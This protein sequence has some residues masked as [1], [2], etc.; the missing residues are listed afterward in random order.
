MNKILTSLIAIAMLTGMGNLYAAPKN[1]CGSLTTHY[2]PFDYRQRAHLNIAI[3]ENAHFTEE[4]EA[5]IRGKSSYLGDDLNYT[6]RAFP[7]HHRALQTVLNYSITHKGIQIP[8][9][10][11]P[12]ECYFERAV[13]FAPD[14]GVAYALY[15]NFLNASGKPDQAVTMFQ[16]AVELDPE[17][18]V[19]NYNLGLLYIKKNDYAKANQYAQKAYA[20]GF[21]L[22]GLKNQLKAAGKWEDKP[23]N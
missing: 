23:A 17:S 15:G 16:K 22:Q 8:G 6:L 4:V 19:A 13:R 12:S 1:F 10:N 7:N 14:D 11:L 5:G 2:G 9:A 21:P 18:G 20:L 3:V